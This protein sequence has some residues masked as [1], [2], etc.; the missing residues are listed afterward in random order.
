MHLFYTSFVL[1]VLSACHMTTST[2]DELLSSE[3][4]EFCKG[5]LKAIYPDLVVDKCMIVP[6]RIREKISKEWGP[7]QVQL[8]SADEEKKYTLLMVDPDAPSRQKPSRAYWRHWLLVDIKHVCRWTLPPVPLPTR[9]SQSVAISSHH[10]RFLALATNQRA[11]STHLCHCAEHFSLSNTSSYAIRLFIQ[12][13][14]CNRSALGHLNC[15]CLRPDQ[16]CFSPTSHSCLS[17]SC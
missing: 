9:H 10:S 3:D 1:C 12:Q 14:P 5:K 13:L 8:P 2:C 16:S 4:A 11:H 7:P 6:Q 15:S 17:R